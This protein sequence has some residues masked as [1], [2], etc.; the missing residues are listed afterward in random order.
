[1]LGRWESFLALWPTPEACAAAPLAAVLREWQ[2][3]GYPRRARGL[4][5]TATVVAAKGWPESE[6]GL[7]E[8]PGVG[9]Y[10][11]RALMVLA[12]GA[13]PI[14]PQ[15]VNIARVTARAALGREPEDVRQA[16]VEEQLV[17]SAA[18]RHERTR[19]HL[20]T[21]RHWSAALQGPTALQR[22][23]AERHLP[24]PWSPRGRP[25][26]TPATLAALSGQH[27][28]AAGRR[29]SG[30]ARRTNS[31]QHRRAAV[32]RRPSRRRPPAGRHR[33]R[34]R[35]ARPRGTG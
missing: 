14:P 18:S 15:D 10:T 2:G 19:L 17:E 25:N 13:G 33:S 28:R 7:R 32:A 16:A 23:P 5:E 6:G 1:M 35:R 11:A 12:F 3:L 4:H 24:G 29:P 9:R 20:R 22:M 31:K 27:P 26:R 34:P 30:H 21:L 8:L